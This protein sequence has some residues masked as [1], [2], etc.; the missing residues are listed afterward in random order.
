MERKEP[1]YKKIKI[2]KEWIKTNIRKPGWQRKLY[3]SNVNYFINSI[4]NNEF[5]YSL[6]VLV[7]EENNEKLLLLDGQ[8]K[9]EAIKMT[10]TEFRIGLEIWEDLTEDEMMNL[11]YIKNYG[12][13]PRIIDMIK[14]SIGR[15]DVLDS[16]LDEKIF[17]INITEKGG[18]NSIRIDRFLNIYKNGMRMII[19][20]HNLSKKNLKEFLLNLNTES[21]VLMKEF[22]TFYKSCF[23]DPFKDNYL[24]KNMIMFT[25]MKF[26]VKNKDNFQKTE[27]IKAFKPIMQSGRIQQE[28]QGVDAI[29]QEILTRS[30]YRTINKYRSKNKFQKFW[31]EEEKK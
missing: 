10:D 21:F 8:H 28:S 6:L 13:Q 30:I 9:L 7:K 2:N 18:V 19:T 25:I 22:C 5:I 20:R 12:K 3:P 26:W 16:C 29:T 27:M 1:I 14:L 24:Y 15:H 23:G 17:P 31:I 11:Y 4:K